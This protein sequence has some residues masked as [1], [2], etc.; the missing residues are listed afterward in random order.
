MKR[1]RG[2]PPSPM[3]S[4]YDRRTEMPLIIAGTAAQCAAAMGVTMNTF[5]SLRSKY[6]HGV[7]G[8]WEIY[9]DE[10]GD[11]EDEAEDG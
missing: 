9:R 2:R 5:Y 6:K 11:E 4:V 3:Y 7:Q 8:R 10:E 1:N